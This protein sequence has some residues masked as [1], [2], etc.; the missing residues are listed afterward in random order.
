MNI[1]ETVRALPKEQQEFVFGKVMDGQSI[2]EA[3]AEC[4]AHFKA[5]AKDADAADERTNGWVDKQ[6]ITIPRKVMAVIMADFAS[7]HGKMDDS[8]TL[9][10]RRYISTMKGH[11]FE[12]KFFGGNVQIIKC[13]KE[14]Q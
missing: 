6:V 11:G 14:E 7:H 1:Q 2:D 13:A 4:Q 8:S 10:G 12:V 9:V 5:P 3:Y